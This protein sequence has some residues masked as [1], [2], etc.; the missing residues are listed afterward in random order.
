[1]ALSFHTLTQAMHM[2]SD[3]DRNRIDILPKSAPRRSQTD[4]PPLAVTCTHTHGCAHACGVPAVAELSLEVHKQAWSASF[5]LS[6][7][8]VSP[9]N[10]EIWMNRRGRV[11]SVAVGRRNQLCGGTVVVGLHSKGS[12]SLA[13]NIVNAAQL[14]NSCQPSQRTTPIASQDDSSSNGRRRSTG[15][16]CQ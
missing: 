5:D 6:P 8:R 9:Y 4:P 10:S 2:M 11:H 1:M 15:R 13:C 3:S 16:S 7:Q 12:A 14:S